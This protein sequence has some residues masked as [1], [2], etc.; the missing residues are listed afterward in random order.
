MAE[1]GPLT[2]IQRDDVKDF[3]RTWSAMDHMGLN[4]N[5]KMAIFAVIAGV[6]HLGN[7]K[8]EDDPTDRKGMQPVSYTTSIRTLLTDNGSIFIGLSGWS[9]F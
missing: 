3:Q 8:F 6:L 9:C 5:E 7:I 4:D 2:D 1:K